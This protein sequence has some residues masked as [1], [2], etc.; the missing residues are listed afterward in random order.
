MIFAIQSKCIRTISLLAPLTQ[1]NLGAAL[2]WLA[3][4]KVEL[5]TRE[6][7]QLVKRASEDQNVAIKGLNGAAE[8]GSSEMIKIIAESQ[9]YM[10]IS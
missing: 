1:V 8:Y 2:V 4:Y 7:R 9:T 10:F 6:L 3:K 5:A